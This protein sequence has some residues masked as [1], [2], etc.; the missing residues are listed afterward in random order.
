MLGGVASSGPRSGD[1]VQVSALGT[2]VPR[3]TE[4]AS[5]HGPQKSASDAAFLE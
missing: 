4:T 3:V 5:V 1:G 2:M